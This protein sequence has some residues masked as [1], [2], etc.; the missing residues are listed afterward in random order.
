MPADRGRFPDGYSYSRPHS[1]VRSSL[2][3]LRHLCAGQIADVREEAIQARARA[4]VSA[5][6]TTH[7]EYFSLIQVNRAR[8]VEADTGTPWVVALNYIVDRIE[9]QE[10]ERLA[11]AS[12]QKPTQGDP[13][14]TLGAGLG[15]GA[16]G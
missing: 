2:R 3:R 10:A 4:L 5:R 13:L 11:H 12:E 1:A 6:N 15:D 8:E 16:L 9:E 14:L 7:P